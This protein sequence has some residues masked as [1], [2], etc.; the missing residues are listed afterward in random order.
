M[1]TFTTATR[2][3][4][5]HAHS[6][7]PHPRRAGL[8]A[9]RSEASIGAKASAEGAGGFARAM[10]SGLLAL[11]VTAILGLIFLTVGVWVAYS[12]PDPTSLSTP[13][14]LGALALSSLLG[15]FVASRRNGGNNAALCGLCGGC[16]FTAVLFILSLLFG[17]EARAT[18]SLGLSSV[19]SWGV[20][21]GV[22]GL[23]ILGALMGRP[24]R[25]SS[26]RHATRR[27]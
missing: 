23:E 22:V 7:T 2:K 24:R 17:D 18:M 10:T 21:A 8:P 26:S 16:L 12:N 1:N 5:R 27:R 20:H 13:L 6:H 14:S 11:P 15:G 4:N 9:P 3:K 25:K 19:A